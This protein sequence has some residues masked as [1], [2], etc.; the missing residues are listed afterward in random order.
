M[1]DSSGVPGGHIEECKTPSTTLQ[2]IS[3]C[4]ASICFAGAIYEYLVRKLEKDLD[5]SCGEK[6]EFKKYHLWWQKE[7]MGASSARNQG[8][9]K[10]HKI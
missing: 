2:E 10:F 3:H 1:G 6:T 5:Y 7:S 9:S 8:F 4:V